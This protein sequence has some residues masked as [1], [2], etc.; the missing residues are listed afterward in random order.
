MRRTHL[1]YSFATNK[2]I[3]YKAVNTFWPKAKAMGVGLGDLEREAELA[4]VLAYHN[5]I[6]KARSGSFEGFLK[7]CVSNRLRNYLRNECK[8]TIRASTVDPSHLLN[9]PSD[10]PS[11]DAYLCYGEVLQTLSEDASEIVEAI[12]AAPKDLLEDVTNT[13]SIK[14]VRGALKRWLKSRGWK[15]SRINEAFT[16][17]GEAFG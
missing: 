4:F 16:E 14:L 17:L 13:E 9:E 1:E 15:R 2:Q 5:W 12:F 10:E 6:A 7:T 3:V 8:R 11:P